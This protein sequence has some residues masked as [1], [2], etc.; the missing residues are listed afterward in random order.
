[1]ECLNYS[2]DKCANCS[3]GQQNYCK[4]LHEKLE[5]GTYDIG[6]DYWD[7]LDLVVAEEDEVKDILKELGLN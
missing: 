4:S 1:M 3:K 6:Q 5:T 7:Y 2:T